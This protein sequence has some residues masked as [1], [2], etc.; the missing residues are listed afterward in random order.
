VR[1]RAQIY[2]HEKGI[3]HRDLKPANV[4]MANS[5]SAKITDYGVSWIQSLGRSSVPRSEVG[6]PS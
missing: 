2:L 5:K 6:A 1:L 4:L 3:I